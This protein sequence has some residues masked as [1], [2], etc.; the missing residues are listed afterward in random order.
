[1]REMTMQANSKSLLYL[2]TMVAAYF[3]LNA[4][5]QHAVS[6]TADLDQ[7]EQLILS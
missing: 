5:T 4:L 1:M 7:A 2:W 6:G 3:C